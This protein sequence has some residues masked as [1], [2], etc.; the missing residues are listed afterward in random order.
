MKKRYIALIAIVVL[1]IVIAGI[2]IYER[3]HASL[4]VN[5]EGTSYSIIGGADGPTSIF[6]AGKIGGNDSESNIEAE[7]TG[8]VQTEIQ[9]GIQIEIQIGDATMIAELK[10]NEAASTLIGLLS[11]DEI[12]M[13]ASNY[14]GFEKVCSIGQSLSRDDEQITTEPGDIMLYNGN[15]LVIFY[16]SNSWA[17]TPIGHIDASAKE[18]EGFLSGDE[19]EVI[20]RLAE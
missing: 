1:I 18:L 17:Y 3:L 19:D 15:Q 13:S 20:I 10:N 14:G 7:E 11:S 9:T 12:V 2:F 8:K 4:Y 16:D 6:I 5:E